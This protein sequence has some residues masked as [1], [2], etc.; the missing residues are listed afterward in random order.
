VSDILKDYFDALERLQRG[1][2]VKVPK[3]TKISNDSVSL[4]AGRRKG[5]IKKSRPMFHQ[6][7][8]AISSAANAEAEDSPNDGLRERLDQ[9]KAEAARNRVLWEESMA[10]EISLFRELLEVREAWAKERETMSN[11]KLVSILKRPS[12]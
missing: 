9:A 6:L 10:R 5:T 7:I 12:T 1:K 2:P 8:A 3:G 4:E 11:G